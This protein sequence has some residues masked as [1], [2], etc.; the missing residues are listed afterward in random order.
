[1]RTV[2]LALL[3][4]CAVVAFP[5]AEEG[6][7]AAAADASE[8]AGEEHDSCVFLGCSDP[9][10]ACPEGESCINDRCSARPKCEKDEECTA[11]GEKCEDGRC[12]VPA[13]T[14]T[15]TTEKP[16]K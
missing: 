9:N 10:C 4:V 7:T 15:S 16:A 5:R 2:V 12:A 8:T 14:T 6:E 1:M 11:E 3:F 13:S